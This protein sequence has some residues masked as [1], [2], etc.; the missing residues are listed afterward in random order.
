MWRNGFR[1]DRQIPATQRYDR[2]KR[3]PG[4]A[5]KPGSAPR[6]CRPLPKNIPPFQFRAKTGMF[7]PALF[8]SG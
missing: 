2:E 4:L 1:H 3:M 8:M 6:Y 5:E 7:C